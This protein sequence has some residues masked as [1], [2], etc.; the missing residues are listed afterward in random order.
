MTEP[1]VIRFADAA[2]G[3]CSVSVREVEGG[4]LLGL[5]L[6]ST[7]RAEVVLLK[8]DAVRLARAV[9]DAAGENTA[10]GRPKLPQS[11]QIGGIIGPY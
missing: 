9:L 4:V 6:G 7:P 11:R 3:P 10:P 8:A 2:R 5:A 1:V